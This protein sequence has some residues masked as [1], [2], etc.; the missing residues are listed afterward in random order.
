MDCT[1]KND[2]YRIELLKAFARRRAQRNTPAPKPA[3]DHQDTIDPQAS[4]VETQA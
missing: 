3:A 4:N 1:N 2:G